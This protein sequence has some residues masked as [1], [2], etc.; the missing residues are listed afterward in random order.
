MGCGRAVVSTPF[1]HAKDIVSPERGVLTKFK[2]SASFTNAI[3]K[4]I[5]NPCLKESMGKNAYAYTRQMTWSNVARS[6]LSLVNKCIEIPEPSLEILPD[7]T[8]YSQQQVSNGQCFLTDTKEKF[9]KDE[10]ILKLK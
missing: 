3:L 8:I 10:I 5:S 9:K 7:M 6:Y 4:I 1:L 2:S